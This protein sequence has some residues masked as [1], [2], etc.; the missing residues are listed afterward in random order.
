MVPAEQEVLVAQCDK[1]QV[2]VKFHF[3]DAVNLF[4][5]LKGK[6]YICIYMCVCVCV[7]SFISERRVAAVGNTG[8]YVQCLN[9]DES[10]PVVRGAN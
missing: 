1:H 9:F 10:I 3:P 2:I 4:L 8:E 5:L 7:C 6:I